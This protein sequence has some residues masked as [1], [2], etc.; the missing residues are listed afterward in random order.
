M[1]ISLNQSKKIG[2]RIKMD[3]DILVL[4]THVWI[5]LLKIVE[6][7]GFLPHINRGVK[8]HLIK[9]P[10][11]SLWEVSML[12]LKNRIVLSETTLEWL[13]SA[14]SAPGISLQPLTPEIAYE[15]TA[16]PGNFHGDPADRL[17][18]S[19]TRILNGTLLTADKEILKYSK[20]GYVKT[21]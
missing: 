1:A 19:T 4:D 5:W 21:L 14:L 16:L 11:I 17:I 10:A 15:S 3:N 7:S 9:I 18:V 20:S 8:N 6:K 2:K 12:S 13:K